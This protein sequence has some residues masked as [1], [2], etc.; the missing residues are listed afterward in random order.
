MAGQTLSAEMN[1]MH[2]R[3]ILGP[4]APRSVEETGLELSFIVD[5][6]LKQALMA[7]EFTLAELAGSTGLALAVVD[8]AVE[9]LRRERFVEI[10]GA[11]E[12]VKTAFRFAIT[13]RGRTRGNDLMEVCRYVGP[14]PVTLEAYRRQAEVQSIRRMHIAEER[15]RA[16]FAD[17][18]LD[19]LLLDRLGPA[20]AAGQPILFYGPTGNG[21]TSIAQ[22]VGEM[23]PDVVHIPHALLVGGHIITVFDPVHHRRVAAAEKIDRRWVPVRR[24][25]I[26]TGG[27]FTLRMLD[28]D[29]NPAANFHEAPLQVKANHGLFIVDDFGRQAIDPQALLNRWIVTLD[30]GVDFLCLH[31]GMKFDIPFDQL[32]ILS[33][34]FDPHSLL[35]EASLRRIRYKICVDRP[36]ETVFERI[37]RQACDRRGIDFDPGAFAYL[38]S[39]YY[40]RLGIAPDACHA[41]DIVEHVLERAAYFRQTPT[42]NR[43]AID[44]AWA[45]CFLP[46]RK[47]P[48][49]QDPALLDVRQNYS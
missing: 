34:N 35:D 12:F 24:P 26:K 48:Q 2:Q 39:Q 30:R 32:V 18:V 23:L 33:T 8:R 45:S 41:R 16:A 43:A 6:L 21:K 40:R 27:E 4:A 15:V 3:P 37:F 44:A 13:D 7:G 17:F 29:F 31:T 9:V 20:V 10:K 11:T 14:A 28:L 36:D 47:K 49:M 38:N 42:L 25:V 1:P 5:L 19:D 46:P 22:T